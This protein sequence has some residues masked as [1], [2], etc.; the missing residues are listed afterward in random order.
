MMPSHPSHTVT[1][2]TS[3]PAPLPSHPS[4]TP[5]EGV[6]CDAAPPAPGVVA[7]FRGR[8]GTGAGN[9]VQDMS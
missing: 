7:N 4:H 6:T 8:T 3:D 1:C 5:I 2:D 9:V